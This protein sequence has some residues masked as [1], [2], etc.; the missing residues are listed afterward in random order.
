MF[1]STK[2]AAVLGVRGEP[3]ID[4]LPGLDGLQGEPGEPGRI[5]NGVPGEPGQSGERGLK[6]NRGLPGLDVSHIHGTYSSTTLFA[7]YFPCGNR[8]VDVIFNCSTEKNFPHMKCKCSTVKIN[9][10]L[11]S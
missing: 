8:S 2:T 9:F 11:N 5:I 7:L 4:G 10:P 6:G 3:G 1:F